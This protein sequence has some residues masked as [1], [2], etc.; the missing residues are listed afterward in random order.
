MLPYWSHVSEADAMAENKNDNTIA[1]GF[2]TH[3]KNWIP[4]TNWV[5]FVT[6]EHAQS[7]YKYTGSYTGIWFQLILANAQHLPTLTLWI[8]I[9]TAL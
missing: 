3:P 5:P 7:S 1:I 6:N 9:A 8:R 4:F 2:Y